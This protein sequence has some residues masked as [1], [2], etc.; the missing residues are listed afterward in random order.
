MKFVIGLDAAAKRQNR[1]VPVVYDTDRLINGHAL[2]LGMSGAGK[3][4][5][6]KRMVRSLAQQGRRTRI[7]IFD[8][9]GDINIDGAS[10]VMYSPHTPYGLNPL[11]VNPDRHFG[12]VMRA[13]DNFFEIVN[14]TVGKLGARQEPVLRKIL[15]DVFRLRG[16]HQEDP[17][18]WFVDD[19]E[20]H[21]LSDGSDNRLYL[22]VPIH[23]KDDAKAFGARWDPGLRAWWIATDLYEGGITRWLPKTAGRSYPTIDDVLAYANRLVKMS[24]MGSDQNAVT[25]L[26]IFG[27]AAAAMHRRKLDAHKRNQG[28]PLDEDHGDDALEKAK[29]KAIDAYAR[30]VEAIRTGTEFDDLIKYDSTDTL[31]SVVDRLETL[32]SYG[33]F[34]AEPAPFDPR[35][36]VWVH[37]LNPLK[38]HVATMFVL[39]RLQEIFDEGLQRGEVSEV[40]DV[41]VLD[42]VRRYADTDILGKLSRESRKF[43]I[44]MIAAGQNANLPDDFI[45]SLATKIVLGID[46]MY[47]KQAEGK[48][49]MER[50]LLE[51]IKPQQ[52][53][54]VQMKTRGA[55]KNEWRWVVLSDGNRT[56]GQPGEVER[57]G[58]AA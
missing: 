3:T 50:R 39:F 18:T 35:A 51:W 42:E 19:D 49:N 1:D 22:D 12:G 52:S 27:K 29:G 4:F 38:E 10:E 30:A 14:L 34:K 13:I 53:M 7:H 45:S 54:A 5:T 43:G 2:L 16:F 21:L 48:M 46:E 40:L 20:S 8:V 24:F 31:R 41:V 26:E 15:L 23:E 36:Q 25:Q 47:W 28:A 17:S 11:R 56:G 44:A 57:H 6:L 32:K 55:T 37:K 58:Q 9:H 33:I